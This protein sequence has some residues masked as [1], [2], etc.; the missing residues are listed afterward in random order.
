MPP[1]PPPLGRLPRPTPLG[2]RHLDNSTLLGDL[3]FPCSDDFHAMPRLGPAGKLKVAERTAA[4]IHL[5]KQKLS[6]RE[7]GER[8]GCS[9]MTAFKD[10]KRYMHAL[11][12][13]AR[14]GVSAIRATEY[15]RLDNYAACLERRIL[16]DHEHDKIKDAVRVSES[17][18]RIYGADIPAE[19]RISIEHRRALSIELVQRLQVLLDPEIYANVIASLATDTTGTYIL[20]GTSI[21]VEPAQAAQGAT[22]QAGAETSRSAPPEV[23]FEAVGTAA[24]CGTT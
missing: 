10:I 12:Q 14:D 11:D 9:H 2:P 6:L 3:Q 15:E 20:P 8:L 5:R 17:M 13:E 18:R 19:R 22:H 1:P 16:D 23:A 4:A 24:G 7:I 21:D